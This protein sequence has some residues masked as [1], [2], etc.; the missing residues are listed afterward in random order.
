MAEEDFRNH[1]VNLVIT[2]ISFRFDWKRSFPAK[3][4]QA[5]PFKGIDIRVFF[6][7]KLLINNQIFRS[8][9]IKK[10]QGSNGGKIED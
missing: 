4:N 5:R 8:P 9:N 6:H 1:N 7:W 2:R 3:M 10:L